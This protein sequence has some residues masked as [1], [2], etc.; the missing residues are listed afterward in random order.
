[1]FDSV[2]STPLEYVSITCFELGSSFATLFKKAYSKPC[3]TSEM[4][5]FAKIVNGL[6]PLTVF[7]KSSILDLGQ[8]SEHASAHSVLS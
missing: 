7:T 5:L 2:L 8:G 4:E 1:M 6:K 3:L